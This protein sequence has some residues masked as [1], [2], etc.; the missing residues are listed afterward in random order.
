MTAATGI[1]GVMAAGRLIFGLGAE[2]LIVAVTAALAKWF[3]SKELSFAFGLNLTIARLGS[4]A[5]LNSPRWA[6]WA[7]EHWQ[8]PLLIAVVFGTLCIIGPLLYAFM[9]QSRRTPLLPWH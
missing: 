6:G 1:F 9:E 3:R 8:W 5:A 2:S 7:Y 4:F